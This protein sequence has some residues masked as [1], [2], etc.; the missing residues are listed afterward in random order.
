MQQSKLSAT[1][2]IG[3]MSSEIIEAVFRFS[4]YYRKQLML[5][6][7]KNQIDYSGGYVNNWNTAQYCLYYIHIQQTYQPPIQTSDNKQYGN[8]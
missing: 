8:R 5:I 6:A 3:P 1:L 4:H 7:S 2:G